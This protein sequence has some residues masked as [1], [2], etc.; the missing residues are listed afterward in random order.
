MGSNVHF[1]TLNVYIFTVAEF[2]WKR[3]Y[4]FCTG[5]GCPLQDKALRLFPSYKTTGTSIEVKGYWGLMYGCVEKKNIQ[6]IF[7][8]QRLENSRRTKSRFTAETE[9]MYPIMFFS[10]QFNCKHE[11]LQIVANTFL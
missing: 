7:S 4:N 1:S 9:L 3:A 2:L 11:R 8:K 6:N 10:E 5:P